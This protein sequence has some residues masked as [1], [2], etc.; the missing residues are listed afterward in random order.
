MKILGPYFFIYLYLFSVLGLVT[1]I[2]K[3]YALKEEISRKIVHVMVGLS[4]FIIVYFFKTSI[5]GIIIPLSFVILNTI[6]YKYNFI[7][8]MER[9]DKSSL[10]TI[11]F[12]ISY[13]VLAFISY[14]KPEFLAFYGMGAI[15]MTIGDGL[16]PI[17]AS[18]WKTSNIFKTTKTYS[19]SIFIFIS[20]I[21]ICLFF[22]NFYD[23][24]YF[25]LNYLILGISASL[26]ELFSK[27]G[28]DNLTLP[29]GLAILG[30]LLS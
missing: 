11:Y 27:K 28:I 7:K 6:A 21:L 26:L 4:W 20:T 10:G 17:I 15:T 8:V 5:H 13:T 18:I 9:K 19:G 14:L 2:N 3:K 16:A 1:W 23:L 29:I 25:L 30:F 22:N 24:D 12:A